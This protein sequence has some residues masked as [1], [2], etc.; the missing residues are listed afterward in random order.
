MSHT[1][2]PHAKVR[3]FTE[4]HGGL[5]K[6]VLNV[7]STVD[8]LFCYFGEQCNPDEYV[9]YAERFITGL[10][11]NSGNLNESMREQVLPAFVLEVFRRSFYVSQIAQGFVGNLE[12]VRLRDAFLQALAEAPETKNLL[13]QPS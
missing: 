8:P 6:L 5:G 2:D 1:Y 12:I 4:K 11:E 13:F 10:R 9:G 7:L 3:L